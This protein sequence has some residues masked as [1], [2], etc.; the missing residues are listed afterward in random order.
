MAKYDVAR[1]D[2]LDG[3]GGKAEIRKVADEKVMQN[4]VRVGRLLAAAEDDGV[5]ALDVQPR[6]LPGVAGA[7]DPAEAGPFEQALA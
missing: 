6:G 2:E 1:W 3:V 7:L 5:A 4:R